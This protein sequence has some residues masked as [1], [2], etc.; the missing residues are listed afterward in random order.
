MLIRRFVDILLAVCALSIA[1]AACGPQS[2]PAQLPTPTA[3][4]AEETSEPTQSVP[5][6]TKS[7]R[8]QPALGTPLSA[9]AVPKN[10]P[11]LVFST[12]DALWVA[13]AN[14]SEASQLEKGLGRITSPVVAPSGGYA[15]YIT[16][17]TA[18]YS[19][20][21][22]RLLRLPSGTI[23]TITPLTSAATAIDPNTDV[24]DLPGSPQMEIARAILDVPSLAWSPDGTKLAFIGAMKGASADLYVYSLSGGSIKQLTDG[25]SQG[26]R[27]TW[28]PD[29]KTIVHAGAN[30]FGTG[31]GY[32]MAGVWAAR[33]DGSRVKTLYV[34][35]SG[36]EVFVGWV[37]NSA[38]LVYSWG[39]GCGPYNLRTIDVETGNV[40]QVWSGA[41]ST[42]GLEP[43]VAYD[44]ATGSVLIALDE[45][46]AD[47][48]CTGDGQQQRA[49][50][51]LTNI[52]RPNPRYISDTG[53]FAHIWDNKSSLFFASIE[54]G[55]VR[56]SANG[57]ITALPAPTSA[58]PVISPDG[59][60]WVWT[61]S[62][63]G[64]KPAGLWVGP[65]GQKTP[66]LVFESAAHYATWSPDSQHIFFFTDDGL[67]ATDRAGSSLA[68]VVGVRSASGDAQWVMP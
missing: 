22:L 27:P 38:F 31:A 7:T 67:Y 29:G 51:Y 33:A 43:R 18:D 8:A 15:A 35:D 65:V 10:G 64:D 19:G 12:D 21:E 52:K 13:N 68:L 50:L 40:T 49:G 11:W 56:I 48:F 24:E 4:T 23:K 2:T 17:R 54:E 66:T 14:G 28:S 26:Y 9:Q 30:G 47:T 42:Q 61:N 46:A 20:L 6:P 25:P 5:T 41:F 63:F 45:F 62:G 1:A 53:A 37:S 44:P 3:L 16:A 34:P 55:A 57:T 59:R 39:G 58:T 32:A 60:S 36:D